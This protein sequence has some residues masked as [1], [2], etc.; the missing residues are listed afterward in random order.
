VRPRRSS[1][2]RIASLLPV[3][4]FVLGSPAHAQRSEPGWIGIS[5]QVRSTSDKAVSAGGAV[6]TDVYDG[7]PAA[8]AGIRPGDRVLAINDLRSPDDFANL[9]D[10]LHLQA[11]DRVRVR[12]ERDGRRID[13]SLRATPRPPQVFAG[14]AMD[15]SF[16]PDSMAEA[17]FRAMD[18]LRIHL[19]QTTGRYFQAFAPGTGYT[20]S[21][22]DQ[23]ET[24]G[25]PFEFFVFHG[26]QHDSL[27][28]ELQDLNQRLGDLRTRQADRLQ[29]LG[30][31]R[32]RR[33]ADTTMDDAQLVALRSAIEDVTRQSAAVRAAMVEAAKA[34][35]GFEYS[36]PFAADQGASVDDPT[37][38]PPEPFR[39]LTPYLL[40]SDRVAG[41]QVVDLQPEL[42]EY[43]K[44]GGG[45][46]VV[47]VPRGTPA[48][49][50]GIRPGDVVV[51]LDK[52]G[53]RSVEDLRFG[54]SQA[55]DSLPITVVRQGASI[56]VLLRRR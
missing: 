18:S 42:A 41:A 46:L 47:D 29:Q 54:I 1:S 53:V 16:D 21:N 17:M 43:F 6:I 12:L 32:S 39:P 30:V 10:R 36:L 24:V 44:V 2:T 52:V 35:A 8:T 26:E 45:V 56:Q 31:S 11:G 34:T 25:V 14:P 28:H 13:V 15:L 3:A 20:A 22:R 9:P 19:M 48:D 49:I 51:R 55:G 50:A 7:G 37:P 33:S 23:H 40:G 5:L 27:R 38:S 4:L